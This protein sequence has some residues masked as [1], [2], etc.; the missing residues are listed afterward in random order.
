MRSENARTLSCSVAPSRNLGIHRGAVSRT[1]DAGSALYK[2]LSCT[3]AA[4]SLPASPPAPV[5]PLPTST[6]RYLPRLNTHSPTATAVFVNPN[7]HRCY[8]II[9][10]YLLP[11]STSAAPSHPR[12]HTTRQSLYRLSILAATRIARDPDHFRTSFKAF[13]LESW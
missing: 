4:L 12:R 11:A 3:C 9:Q 1:F 5:V 6:R 8:Y 7:K 13:V 2:P 10:Y